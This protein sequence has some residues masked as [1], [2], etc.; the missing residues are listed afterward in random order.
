MLKAVARC[1]AVN[2]GRHRD[3]PGV[4]LIIT[5]RLLLVALLLVTTA[6]NHRIASKSALDVCAMAHDTIALFLDAPSQTPVRNPA[7]S[8]GACEFT[9]NAHQKDAVSVSVSV[10]TKAAFDADRQDFEQTLRVILAEASQTFGP[11]PNVDLTDTAK[12]GVAYIPENS[13][14]QVIL[15][16]RGVLLEI[17]VRGLPRD[18]IV[19]LSRNIWRTLL[20]YKPTA[21][22]KAGRISD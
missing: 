13:S 20:N 7:P 16:E 2:D 3:R 15:S 18:R 4:N 9:A 8:A 17:G 19:D 22:P 1:V 12:V 21:Q 5:R 6:C 11:I 14:S 10:Y